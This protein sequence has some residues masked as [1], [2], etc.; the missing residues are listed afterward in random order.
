MT[1]RVVLIDDEPLARMRLRALLA[2][3]TMPTDVMGEFG[4][5]MSAWQA[6]QTWRAAGQTPDVLFLDVAMPGPDGLY[7]ARQLASWPQ[8]PA[9]VFVTAHAQHAVTAFELDAIDYLTKPVRLERLQACLARV[10]QRVQLSRAA[11]T[12]SAQSAPEDEVL[13]IQERGAMVRVPLR[14]ILYFK[15]EQKYVTVHTAKRTWQMDSSLADLAEHMGERFIRV[16]R[17]ALVACEAMVQLALRLDPSG[18]PDAWFLQLA[19]TDEWLAVSR[20][21]VGLVK[22]KMARRSVRG[23]IDAS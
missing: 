21:Q 18:G 5:V 2:Q 7:L 15:A 8:A 3:A 4:E 13:L 9:L 17:N 11:S 1:L 19:G 14:D 22:E 12:P 20:R 16:H 6:L 10:Q 23:A